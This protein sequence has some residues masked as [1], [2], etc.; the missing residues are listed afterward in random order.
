MQDP[1]HQKRRVAGPAPR[2][3]A[4]ATIVSPAITRRNGGTIAEYTITANGPRGCGEGG[5]AGAA[6]RFTDGNHFGQALR[7][8]PATPGSLRG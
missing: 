3:G 4:P 8:V 6:R 7:A 1:G 5:R 2:I